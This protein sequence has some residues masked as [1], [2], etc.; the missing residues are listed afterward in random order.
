MA[1]VDVKGDKKRQ[2]IS[3][4]VDYPGGRITPFIPYEFHYA[5]QFFV[6][7]R[8]K[9]IIMAHKEAYDRIRAIIKAASCFNDQIIRHRVNDGR[10]TI[11]F[12]FATEQ[13]YEKFMEDIDVMVKGAIVTSDVFNK[14]EKAVTVEKKP[15][16]DLSV[17]YNYV[18]LTAAV[19]VPYPVRNNSIFG[20]D[21]QSSEDYYI[22]KREEAKTLKDKV[23]YDRAR[24]IMK[25]ATMF[26][27]TI[28]DQR[29]LD[30]TLKVIFAFEREED[31]KEFEK[32]FV[33]MVESSAL[34]EEEPNIDTGSGL[35]LK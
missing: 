19:D 29:T 35:V 24:A 16:R 22:M 32:D 4:T 30:G 21:L 12:L 1:L 11:D 5:E 31:L 33:S 3:V 9:T 14:E 25:A 7:K 28:Y 18:N 8:D 17:K 27:T 2:V 13:D 15:A 6:D 10:M 23:M 34:T 26:R 20:K